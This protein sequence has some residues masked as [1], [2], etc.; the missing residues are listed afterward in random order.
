MRIIFALADKL[1]RINPRVRVDYALSKIGPDTD[2]FFKK[3]NI[4]LIIDSVDNNKARALLNYFSQKYDIPFISGGT[5]Y[6]SGQVIVCVPGKTACLN[7][8][9]DIDTMA[10]ESHRPHQSCIY[11]PQPS[12]I[13][14]NQI[15]AG[16]I[17]GEAKTILQEDKY[18]EPIHKILK[19]VSGEKFRLAALPT[20]ESCDCRNDR[21]YMKNWMNRMGHIYEE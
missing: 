21:D 14:S 17:G 18:G 5:R 12:V 19:Y 20:Q 10:L 15:A 4:D 13:T 2:N 16:L 3:N 9:V 1:K 6:D 7:T 11:A 8:Q